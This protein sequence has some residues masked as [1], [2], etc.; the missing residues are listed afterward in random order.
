MAI[1]TP[2]NSDLSKVVAESLSEALSTRLKVIDSDLSR[3]AYNSKMPT[4]PF[5]MTADE[6]KRSGAAIG[7]DQLILIRAANQ[8]RSA[9]GRAEYYEAYAVIYVVSSR[10][11][12]LIHWA[13]HKTEAKVPAAAAKLLNDTTT[14]IADEIKAKIDVAAKAEV[15]EAPL[16]FMEEP[17]EANSPNAKNFIAPIPFRRIKPEYTAEAAFY[18]VTA[19]VELMV[20]LD[21]AGK[22]LRTEIVRWAGYGLDESVERAVRQM[23]WRPAERNGKTLPMRFLLRY[24]FKKVDKEPL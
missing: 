23:N 16:S 1:I 19:T 2:Y 7:C 15:A 10:T 22:I 11:G 12:R 21:E 17:P 3:T 6:S 5:N 24:N 8:R 18:E 13:L 20:D 9:F 4:D 14:V